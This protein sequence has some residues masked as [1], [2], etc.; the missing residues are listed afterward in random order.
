MKAIMSTYVSTQSAEQTLQDM[1]TQYC[2]Q[3]VYPDMKKLIEVL[4]QLSDEQKL[5]VLQ[6]EYLVRK[7]P[8]H[9]A[10]LRGHTEIISTLL[11]SLPSSANR[12]KLLMVDKYY[13]PLRLAVYFGHTESVRMILDCLT[14][15]Q[16]IQLMPVQSSGDMTAIQYAESTGC[17]DTV[18]ILRE[19]QQR[20]ENLIREEYS[21]LIFHNILISPCVGLWNINYPALLSGYAH[22]FP[23]MK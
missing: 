20:A 13:T 16:Q 2:E 1:M 17:R 9:N 5:H 19:Y 11:T 4:T 10:A 22:I 3:Y 8:L 7:A 12:L 14:A 23:R 6:Q 18:R 15:D 21:K